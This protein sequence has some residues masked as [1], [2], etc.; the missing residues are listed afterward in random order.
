MVDEN[1]K[2]EDFAR[3]KHIF[4]ILAKDGGIL[5]RSGHTE[6]SRAS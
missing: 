5:R 4:P 1:S 3:P 6:A 2:L